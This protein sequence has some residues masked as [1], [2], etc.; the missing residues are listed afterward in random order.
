M[1]M[2]FNAKPGKEIY[3]FYMYALIHYNSRGKQRV[4]TSGNEGNSFAE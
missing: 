1:R 2:P 3:A 4:K